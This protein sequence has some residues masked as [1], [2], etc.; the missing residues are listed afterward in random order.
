VAYGSIESV[1]TITTR[2]LERILQLCIPD[3][4]S[5]DIISLATDG[6]DERG[7]VSVSGGYCVPIT[8]Y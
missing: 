3:C 6:R 1:D 7:I 8:I 2:E 4:E 5:A